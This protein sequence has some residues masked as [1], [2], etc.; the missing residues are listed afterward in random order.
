M[1]KAFKTCRGMILYNACFILIFLCCIITIILLGVFDFNVGY[2]F[3]VII[4]MLADFVVMSVNFDRTTQVYTIKI[5]CK[6]YRDFAKTEFVRDKFGRYIF[7]IKREAC[8]NTWHAQ[9]GNERFVFDMTGYLFPKAYI[10]TYFI[11][12]IHYITLNGYCLP[13]RE[14]VHSIDLKDNKFQNVMLVFEYNG[15]QAKKVIVQNG[16]SKVSLWQHVIL[17]TPFF[18]VRG[19][20]SK[21]HG[22]TDIDYAKKNRG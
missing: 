2:I 14:L 21:A 22:Y 15:K 5:V 19:W 3:L 20:T 16:R 1:Y 10:C 12:N 6:N 7:T 8:G 11:R 13:M 18:G 4:L 17:M 9:N